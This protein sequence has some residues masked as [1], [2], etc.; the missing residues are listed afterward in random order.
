MGDKCILFRI[1]VK[2]AQYSFVFLA[3][4]LLVCSSFLRFLDHNNETP[5]S[6]G[7][8][9]T[10]DQPVTETFL[11]NNTQ[12]LTTDRHT[13][14][15]CDSNPQSQQASGLR[16]RGHWDWQPQFKSINFEIYIYIYYW[17]LKYIK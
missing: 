13:C 12:S 6:V 3:R 10:S 9:S 11:P 4:H 1:T 15:R 17:C 14:P 16:P 5:Q 7:L 2:V 8:L